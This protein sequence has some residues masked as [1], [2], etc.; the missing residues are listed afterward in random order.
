MQKSK[1]NALGAVLVTVLVAC[2]QSAVSHSKPQ[3][4]SG[5]RTVQPPPPSPSPT[6]DYGPLPVPGA[7]PLPGQSD[8]ISGPLPYPL[9][10]QIENTDPARP[11]AGLQAAS[12][13]FESIS[14][15]GITRFSAL[16]HR[17][18]GVVGPVRSARF[19]SV[20]LYHRFGALLMASGGS[21]WTY[22]KIFAD[23]SIPAI[24]N[25]FDGGRHFFRWG[26]RASP[27]NLYTSQAQMVNAG[28]ANARPGQRED[29]PR[30]PA[31]P[32]TEPAPTV[33][34]P[35]LR[36]QFDYAGDTYGVVTDG[37]VQND[38]VFGPVRA[39]TVAVLHVRQW[40]TELQEDVTG[41]HARDFDLTS[42][43]FAD[44]Y[45]RGTVVHGHWDSPSPDTPLRLLGP[46]GLPLK[47][48][49]GL[50]WVALAG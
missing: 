32:G 22:Q 30:S 35:D 5:S 49:P 36:S 44:F 26:G 14:E 20:Y 19:V 9:L 39:Q 34:V 21:G 37:Q 27:H 45:S 23:P 6:P 15:G 25:D 11:Q 3:A 16:Y 29:F 33:V 41:G 47:I 12:V 50:V 8:P 43:G 10:I 24:I 28:L 17:V 40:I 1:L 13:I 38:V 2:G 46:D 4:M 7:G 31:W 42:G 48:P 18:P